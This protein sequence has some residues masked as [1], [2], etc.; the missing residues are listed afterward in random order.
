MIA[1]RVD[2]RLAMLDAQ[3]RLEIFAQP[4]M[5]VC[6]GTAKASTSE[7]RMLGH[8]R[9]ITPCGWRHLVSDQGPFP[10]R[11]VTLRMRAGWGCRG[12]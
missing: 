8:Q 10:N 3:R 2:E 5:A 12:G 7:R 6:Q 1:Q 4:A 9:H 11:R